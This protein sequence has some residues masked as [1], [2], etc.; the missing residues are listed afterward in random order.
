MVRFGKRHFYNS[1]E[2]AISDDDNSDNN[3]SVRQL[4]ATT[5]KPKGDT[6]NLAEIDF[7]DDDTDNVNTE[8]IDEPPEGTRRAS[9][10][11]ERLKAFC[12]V[13]SS[14]EVNGTR[15]LKQG[16][17][18]NVLEKLKDMDKL[19]QRYKGGIG[20]FS[21]S[22]QNT[23]SII[24]QKGGGKKELNNKKKEEIYVDPV[25]KEIYKESLLAFYKEHSPEKITEVDYL[26]EFYHGKEELLFG[27]IETVYQVKFFQSALV[28]LYT[29]R[30]NLDKIKDIEEK[31]KETEID[32]E[33]TEI[34]RE[35]LSV[36]YKEYNPEKVTGVD[37]MLEFYRGKEEVLFGRIETVYQINPFRPALV[38][39]Y[40][41]HDPEKLKDID[42]I[43]EESRGEESK[44]FKHI[45]A[46]Y[47]PS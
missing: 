20:D 13:Q 43:L 35:A 24:R 14:E 22:V 7:A 23:F 33:D 37:D 41:V 12:E 45:K 16:I 47:P 30:N 8:E 1:K 27:R 5:K 28:A 10:S 40:T 39:F 44:V 17:N 15:K 6:R 19:L 3:F 11:R 38:A 18:T 42:T 25:D 34:Y 32:V 46:I 21:K 36:F 4:F 26:L 9:I 2:F 29:A 31:F